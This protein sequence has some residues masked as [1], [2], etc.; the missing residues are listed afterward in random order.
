MK[1]LGSLAF[2][3]NYRL[4]CLYE[5]NECIAKGYLQ[6]VIYELLLGASQA[7]LTSL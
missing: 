1:G 4:S 5:I 2:I 3:C 7:T 6:S